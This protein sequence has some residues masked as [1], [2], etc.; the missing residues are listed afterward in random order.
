[1]P[2]LKKVVSKGVAYYYIAESIREGPDVQTRIIRKLGRLSPNEVE[3][4]KRLLEEPI[5]KPSQSSSIDIKDF[6][7]YLSLRHGIIAFGHG[8]WKKLGLDRI[9]RESLSHTPNKS[10]SVKLCEIM[11]LNRLEQPCSKL[12][13]LEWMPK[14]SLPFILSLDPDTL[15]DN[16][17][18]RTMDILWERRDGI[19]KKIWEQI[20]KPLTNGTIFQKDITS[21]YFEGRGP[22]TAKYNRYSRDHRPD[23]TQ[24]CWGLVETEEGY[25][26]TMEIYPGNTVDKTTVKASCQ[27][28]KDVFNITTGIFVGDRGLTTDENIETVR[29]SPYEYDYVLAE[30]NSD[31]LEILDTARAKGLDV[32]ERERTAQ[33][34]L[35]GYDVP[36]E[37]ILKGTDVYV[38]EE[39][40]VVAW[41]NEMEN[42]DL[43]FLAKQIQK[44]EE[45]IENANR[46]AKNHPNVHHH[47]ILKMATRNLE[48]KKVSTYFDVFIKSEK[49]VILGYRYQKKVQNE[50][51]NAGYWVLR[52]SLKKPKGLEIIEIYRGK[53]VLEQT[54][55]EIKS[56]LKVRPVRHRKDKRVEV[57]I[58]ICVLGYLLVKIVEMEVRKA[59]IKETGENIFEKFRDIRLNEDGSETLN[60]RWWSVTDR[61]LEQKNVLNALGL[62]DKIFNIKQKLV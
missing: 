13:L 25:P 6:H 20:V 45:I 38:N 36:E 10:R 51:D 32:W 57:H 33:Q 14:T 49:P 18:Y 26:I 61:N 48:K 44:G 9:L 54:F 1:M 59:G 35:P 34:V 46:Y 7:N 56:V 5:V 12:H 27:R 37:Y 21:S 47:K 8:L 41:S 53:W 4:W 42:D 30:T 17:F 52:T 28:L 31:V 40:Y 3:Y 55:R 43:Q 11:V 2:Y 50:K 58:W 62:D 15:Y 24:V 19:E 60:R 23:C 29:S 22:P 16:L 39:R